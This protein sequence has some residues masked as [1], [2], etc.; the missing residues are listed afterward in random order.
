MIKSPDALEA[1]IKIVA[2]QRHGVCDFSGVSGAQKEISCISLLSSSIS[3]SCNDLLLAVESIIEFRP[4][5]QLQA[6]LFK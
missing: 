1:H 2:C 4:H 5:L 6:W 3:F